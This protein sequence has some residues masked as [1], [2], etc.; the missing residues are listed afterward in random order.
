MTVSDETA[1]GVVSADK[2]AGELAVDGREHKT[3]Y[4]ERV[5]DICREF[6]LL[7]VRRKK[8]GED[9][10]S[11][12]GQVNETTLAEI[13]KI[14]LRGRLVV[15]RA[16]GK[17][18]AYSG[19]DGIFAPAT[20][21]EVCRFLA[22]EYA[23]LPDRSTLL[24]P[25]REK[26]PTIRM[27]KNLSEAVSACI[28]ENYPFGGDPSARPGTISRAVAN[29][30]LTFDLSDGS[31]RFSTGLSPADRALHRAP[32]AYAPGAGDK[33]G[34]LVEE[35]L[36]PAFGGGEEM[37]EIFLDDLAS[38]WLGG[39]LHPF[40]LYLIGA[41]DTGK[42]QLVEILRLLHGGA[43]WRALRPRETAEKFGLS[44]LAGPV[45]VVS[46]AD[47][48]GAALIGEMSALLK[49]ATGGDVVED[50]PPHGQLLVAVPGDKVFVITSNAVPKIELEDDSEAWAR[51]LRPWRFSSYPVA[52]R[53]PNFGAAILR[54]EGSALLNRLIEG[55]RR[56]IHLMLDGQ[57]PPVPAKMAEVMGETLRKSCAVTDFITGRCAVCKG[58]HVLR[59]D[60]WN[61]FT[62]HTRGNG[63][64]P[65][66]KTD[67]NERAAAA[68]KRIFSAPIS[69][70]LDGGKGWRGVKF[71]PTE[72]IEHA[73][74]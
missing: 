23:R 16:S 59:I 31:V 12:S 47:T 43:H 50:R 49:A 3:S 27:L 44:F 14:D 2:L 6:G 40:V 66:G 25:L 33:P 15:D 4:D 54:E 41:S 10:G 71:R 38:A 11:F 74:D 35:L 1:A 63:N 68:M 51:R 34:R 53:V 42:S 7:A 30:K 39:G 19:R 46:F 55:A 9:G 36:L 58:S 8:D 24:A 57:R 72:E 73:D 21:E 62:D 26:P 48:K 17:F 22:G 20:R 67:F 61:R 60:L 29:G 37:V 18:F 32:V 13:L 52:R 65:L 45:R 56:R 64:R 5:R 28:G 70:S 69:N